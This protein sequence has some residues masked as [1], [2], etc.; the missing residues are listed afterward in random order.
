MKTEKKTSSFPLDGQKLKHLTILLTRRQHWKE[1]YTMAAQ[2]G[3]SPLE[4]NL[5]KPG[6][7]DDA[8]ILSP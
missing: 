4:S 5:T 1:L 8:H 6:K 2:I 7:A 3:T